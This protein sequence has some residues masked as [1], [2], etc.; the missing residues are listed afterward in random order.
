MILS[1]GIPSKI[2]QM[3]MNLIINVAGAMKKREKLAIETANGANREI[4]LRVSDTGC[5][6]SPEVCAHIFDPFFTTKGLA[7]ASGLGLS[8][9][10]GIVQQ[11][12]GT[13][14]VSSK[15][16]SGS[17]FLVTLPAFGSAN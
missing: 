13:I 14:E 6:M 7:V 2:G 12:G 16:G 4:L 11:H 3:L 1:K 10:Y 8:T 15:P 17:T 5:G 9:V